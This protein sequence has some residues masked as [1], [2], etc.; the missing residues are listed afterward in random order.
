VDGSGN[1]RQM[2]IDFKA[3][4]AENAEYTNYEKIINDIKKRYIDC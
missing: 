4:F 2:C 1:S 3:K